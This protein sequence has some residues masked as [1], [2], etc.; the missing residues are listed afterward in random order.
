M[1]QF[2]YAIQPQVLLA[3]TMRPSPGQPGGPKYMDLQCHLYLT[4]IFPLMPDKSNLRKQL[5]WF[6]AGL[7]H[8]CEEV[9][10]AAAASLQLQS[11]RRDQ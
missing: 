3:D 9:R 8:H 6:T 10:E 7:L 5:F 1:V 2:P 4:I 11:K